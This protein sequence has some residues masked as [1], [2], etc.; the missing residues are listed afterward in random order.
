MTWNTL[1]ANAKKMGFEVVFRSRRNEG[2]GFIPDLTPPDGYDWILVGIYDHVAGFWVKPVTSCARKLN[3]SLVRK[4]MADCD[5]FIGTIGNDDTVFNDANALL[6]ANL[7]GLKRMAGGRTDTLRSGA[8]A[9]VTDIRRLVRKEP[10][11]P[12]SPVIGNR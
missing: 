5:P 11:R 2:G 12:V 7:Q 1:H 4:L 6:V 9:G 10:G 8:S 3:P